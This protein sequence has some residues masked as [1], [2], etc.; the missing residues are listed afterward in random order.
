MITEYERY[1]AK[2]PENIRNNET[3]K[4]VGKSKNDNRQISVIIVY[5]FI[6]IHFPYFCFV[7][8]QLHCFVP[9]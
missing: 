8:F 7:I 5:R 4:E 2:H 9:L 6:Y 1:L 3:V